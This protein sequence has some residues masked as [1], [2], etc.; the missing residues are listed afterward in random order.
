MTN[1]ILSKFYYDKV[2]TAQVYDIAIHTPLNELPLISEKLNHKILIK[3]EDLQPVYSFKCRGAYNKLASMPKTELE[4]GIIAVSAGNHAQGVAMAAQK[5]GTHATIVMPV[6][7]PPIKVNAVKKIGASV[8]LKGDNY[9]DASAYAKKL[10]NQDLKPLIHPYDDPDVIAGQGTIAKEILSDY[11]GHIDAIFVAVGGG[12]L[13]S[14][15]SAYIKAIRPEIKII[16]IEPEDAA[17]MTES[18]KQN[19]RIILDDVG[20]FADGVAVRQVGEEPFKLAQAFVD[21]MITVTTDEICAAIKDIYDNCRAIAEPAGAVGL[22]GLK[23]YSASLKEKN[24]T[25]I[26]LNCGANI[27]FDRLRHVSERAEIGE[28][29]EAL[30]AVEISET[31]GSFKQFIHDIGNRSITEFN[32]RFADTEK[33]QI[34]VGIELKKGKKE[35]L[36]IIRSL[37]T[38]K[39]KIIDLTDNEMAK[40][41]LRHMVGGKSMQN[42]HERLYRFQFPERPNALKQFLDKISS[43]WNISLFHY[44]NHGAAYGRVL[45]GIQVQSSENATFNKFLKSCGYR[46]FDETQNPAYSL[47]L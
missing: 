20:I 24:K 34:F 4:N 6:T 3:R 23:K 1:N 18:L 28:Q 9:D 35:R 47:F 38:N 5:I 2:T 13:I 26:T 7:T 32:Y 40:V 11:T 21:D 8:I 39:Y 44:R 15:I 36:D 31:P 14:G 30:F 25:F 37:E 42:T 10:S 19:S 46:Y 41:H 27:N 43:D 33:A 29:K 45:I 12:G 22:A 17:S 16:G